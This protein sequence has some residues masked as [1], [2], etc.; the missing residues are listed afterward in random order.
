MRIRKILL[1][2]LYLEKKKISLKKYFFG[3]SQ[4]QNKNA[5]FNDPIFSD[6]F[7]P[8]K[9]IFRL[10]SLNMPSYIQKM[11]L[12]VLIFSEGFV[13]LYPTTP[14]KEGLLYQPDIMNVH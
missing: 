3:R 12:A 1:K 7:I 10:L 2:V 6:G 11:T 14:K 8:K 13:S 9:I 5:L 4:Y